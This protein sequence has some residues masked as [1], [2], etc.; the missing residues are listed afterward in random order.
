MWTLIYL[1]S[2]AQDAD[3]ST[4]YSADLLHAF[5]A[6]IKGQG[7]FQK[8]ADPR[9]SR[10]IAG[11]CELAPA[12]LVGTIPAFT[13]DIGLRRYFK[14]DF[15]GSY[16]ELT[17]GP[18]VAEHTTLISQALSIDDYGGI[19]IGA[20][21]KAVLGYKYMFKSGFTFDTNTGLMGGLG[22]RSDLVSWPYAVTPVL[23]LDLDLRLGYSF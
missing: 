4:S 15:Q 2:S 18:R 8:P 6:N 12:L 10:I 14:K 20:Q 13:V 16:Y 23:A 22:A 7:E 3:A 9:S 1:L 19:W 5:I 21:G 17:A 11:S